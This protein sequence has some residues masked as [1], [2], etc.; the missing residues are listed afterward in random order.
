MNE[1]ARER[2]NTVW[3]LSE[4][5]EEYY[6]RKKENAELE[7]RYFD[8][9]ERLPIEQQEIIQDF[10]MSCEGMSWRMLEVACTLMRFPTYEETIDAM[11]KAGTDPAV[12]EAHQR[13]YESKKTHP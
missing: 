1:Q 12:I 5:D 13:W 7:K 10:L 11:R 9:I 8:V 4:G 2:F 6:Q 3:M